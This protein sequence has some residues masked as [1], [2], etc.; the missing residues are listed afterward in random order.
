MNRRNFLVTGALATGAVMF[1][2][3]ISGKDELKKIVL[4][5][6]SIRIGYQPFVIENMIGKAEVWGPEEN[7]GTSSNV[8]KNLHKWVIRQEPHIVH[9]NAGLHDLRTLYYDS[10]PGKNVVP[11]DHYKDNV[12]TII[13]FIK[14]RSGAIVIWATTTPVIY[15]RAHQAHSRGKDFDRHNEDVIMYNKAAVKVAK[16]YDVP[17]NDLYRFVMDADA[18]SIIR[19]DG[20]H[21]TEE[22]RKMQGRYVANYLKNYL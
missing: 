18:E 9:V 6:D 19:K 7:G 17:V 8:V 15:E 13:N 16:K 11:L 10:G 14:T 20:V 22:A 3:R 4:I 21:F 1:P 2:V 12:E 5:G